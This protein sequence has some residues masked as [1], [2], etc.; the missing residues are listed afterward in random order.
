MEWKHRS[1]NRRITEA[2]DWEYQIWVFEVYFGCEG[3]ILIIPEE[4][5]ADTQALHLR[6]RR[7]SKRKCLGHYL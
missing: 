2:W 5:S 6:I 1:P 7:A 4:E 3:T